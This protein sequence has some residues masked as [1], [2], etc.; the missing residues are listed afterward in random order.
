[1]LLRIQNI[2]FKST[3]QY[4]VLEWQRLKKVKGPTFTC[5]Y[6]HSLINMNSIGLQ[7]KLAY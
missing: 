5:I 2:Y 7:F 1:V 4:I 3:A 6:H